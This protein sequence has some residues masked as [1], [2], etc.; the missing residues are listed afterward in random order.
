LFQKTR[1]AM[2]YIFEDSQHLPFSI[3]LEA[4]EILGGV[5]GFELQGLEHAR[6]MLYP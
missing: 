6:H 4:V 2:Q 5:L 1:K 3:P